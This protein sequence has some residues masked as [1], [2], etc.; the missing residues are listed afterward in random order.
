MAKVNNSL[1]RKPSQRKT[2]NEYTNGRQKQ[3]KVNIPFVILVFFN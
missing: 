3:Q 1:E 2:R